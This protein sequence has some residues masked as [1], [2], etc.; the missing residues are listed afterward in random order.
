MNFEFKKH[1]VPDVVRR[2]FKAPGRINSS[3]DENKPQ[4]DPIAASIYGNNKFI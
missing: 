3:D 1:N 4:M 2:K